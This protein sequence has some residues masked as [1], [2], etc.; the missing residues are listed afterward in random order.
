[1]FSANFDVTMLLIIKILGIV[2]IIIFL[3]LRSWQFGVCAG[4]CVIIACLIDQFIFDFV[5]KR[6]Q[7][8]VTFVH[9]N[10]F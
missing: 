5:I 8:Y 1:V 4:C 3:A 2:G 7:I 6:G 9:F 10:N